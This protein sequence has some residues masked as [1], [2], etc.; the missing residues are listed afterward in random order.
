LNKNSISLKKSVI[1]KTGSEAIEMAS[2]VPC[3]MKAAN[4]FAADHGYVWE[5]EKTGA[6]WHAFADVNSIA[7]ESTWR[8]SVGAGTLQG[9]ELTPGNIHKM[10]VELDGENMI[11]YA[12]GV[13]APVSNIRRVPP[14]TTV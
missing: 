9:E 8:S 11:A 3:K 10:V 6:G 5:F 2:D 7:I 4:S 13:A 1:K 14:A 12:W